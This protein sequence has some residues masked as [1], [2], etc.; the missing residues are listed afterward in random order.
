MEAFMPRMRKCRRI[1]FAPDNLVFEPLNPAEGF[2][3]ILEEELESL[4]LSDLQGLDQSDA[5]DAMG[6]SRGTFQRILGNARSKVAD[7]LVHGRVIRI[8]DSPQCETA[9]L[10]GFNSC[11][12]CY[13][14]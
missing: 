10:Q 8:L 9:I 2:V 11:G 6:V 1:G 12:R 13:R 3:E 7:A 4:R 5:A 14:K